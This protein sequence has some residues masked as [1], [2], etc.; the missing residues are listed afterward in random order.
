M[1]I[2]QSFGQAL[3]G[4]F[5]SPARAATMTTAAVAIIASPFVLSQR[6]LDTLA[7]TSPRIQSVA[8]CAIQRTTIDF[9]VYHGFRTEEEQRGMVARGVSWV[10]R[11]RHQDGQAI[12]VMALVNGKGTWEPAPYYEIAKAFYSCGDDLGIPITWGGE[13]RVKDYVHFEEKRP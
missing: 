10:N 11:S 8:H 9:V 5:I 4:L 12:D 6:S 13:W 7:P 3:R 1:T 2:W